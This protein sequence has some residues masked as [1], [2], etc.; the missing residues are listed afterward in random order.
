MS[1]VNKDEA[2]STP[3][4]DRWWIPI[5]TLI[6][7]FPITVVLV[8]VAPP[9]AFSVLFIAP[10]YLLGFALTLGSPLFV[11]LDK[12]YVKSVSAWTPPGWYYLMFFVPLLS[13]VYIY[14]RHKYVGVP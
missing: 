12:Q 6:V 11:H 3:P 7:L 10:V 2:G 13:I 4:E 8:Q 1:Q 5:G 9:D 14:Q